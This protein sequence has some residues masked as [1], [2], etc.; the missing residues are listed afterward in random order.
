MEKGVVCEKVFME[1]I[2][3]SDN[4]ELYCTESAPEMHKCMLM[5]NTRLIKPLKSQEVSV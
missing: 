2:M 1:V 3:K 5:Y 4:K